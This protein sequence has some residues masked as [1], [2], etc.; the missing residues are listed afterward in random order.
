MFATFLLLIQA[1]VEDFLQN[2]D[3]KLSSTLAKLNSAIVD[4]HQLE[5]LP[6]PEIE[7]KASPKGQIIDATGRS[8]LSVQAIDYDADTEA[9][10]SRAPS[11][12]EASKRR[13]TYSRR[14][15]G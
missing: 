5:P 7:L 11:R 9:D 10:A 2:A 15:S 12:Q 13:T 6:K 4:I 3:E 14:K 8:S 1:I